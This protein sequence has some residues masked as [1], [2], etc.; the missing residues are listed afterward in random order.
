MSQELDAS[1]SDSSRRALQSLA[2]AETYIYAFIGETWWDG[3]A[4]FFGFGE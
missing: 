4:L 1:H 2:T 3:G